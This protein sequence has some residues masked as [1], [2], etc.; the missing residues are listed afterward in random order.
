M[1]GFI[2]RHEVLRLVDHGAQ[3]V[4]VLGRRQYEQEHLPGAVNIFLRDIPDKAPETLERDRPV[5]V[6]CED[7]L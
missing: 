2:D 3:L 4:E 5:V 7:T 1:P 6:Y